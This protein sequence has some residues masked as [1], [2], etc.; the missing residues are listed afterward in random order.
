[1]AKA[2]FEVDYLDGDNVARQAVLP[3]HTAPDEDDPEDGVLLVLSYGPPAAID[4]HAVSP[5]TLDAVFGA[6][7]A[8]NGGF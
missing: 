4:G 5:E 2:Y 3:Y 1:M 8:A 7:Q 6:I